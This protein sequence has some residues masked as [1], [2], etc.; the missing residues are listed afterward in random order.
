MLLHIPFFHVVSSHVYMFNVAYFTPIYSFE[1]FY[2][3]LL[4]PLSLAM[5]FASSHIF[6]VHF[7]KWS[8][9][10][11]ERK[12]QQRASVIASI[13]QTMYFICLCVSF[14]PSIG[15]SAHTLCLHHKHCWTKPTTNKSASEKLYDEQKMGALPRESISERGRLGM[16]LLATVLCWLFICVLIF[17]KRNSLCMYVQCTASRV[18]LPSFLH[19]SDASLCVPYHKK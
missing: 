16:T 8:N 3:A 11:C 17:F 7:L 18:S 1:I 19:L 13:V 15:T 14:V 5:A 4:C 2:F 9:A 12:N 10:M 6:A